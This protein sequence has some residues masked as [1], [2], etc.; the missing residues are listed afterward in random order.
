[1]FVHKNYVPEF[2]LVFGPW[3]S[4]KCFSSDITSVLQVPPLPLPSDALGGNTASSPGSPPPQPHHECPSHH[5]AC[6][7]TLAVEMLGPV[8]SFS[9]T[10]PWWHKSMGHFHITNRSYC[11]LRYILSQTMLIYNTWFSQL[12]K[13]VWLKACMWNSVLIE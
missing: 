8:F 13:Q 11:H 4:H 12:M 7:L 1:M 5:L 3:N 10:L 9:G 6:C 2:I